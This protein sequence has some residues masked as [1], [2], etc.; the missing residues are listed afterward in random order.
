MKT[1][2][3]ISLFKYDYLKLAKMVYLSFYLLCFL[4]NTVGEQEGRTGSTPKQGV[5]PN[6]A[7]SCE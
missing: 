5:G 2:Q 6:N 4:S 1:T 7:Y 3:G